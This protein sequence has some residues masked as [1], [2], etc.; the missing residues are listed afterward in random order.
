MRPAI[1]FLQ[2][3]LRNL[4]TIAAHRPSLSSIF[5]K[6][7]LILNPIL[8]QNPVAM[9]SEAEKQKAGKVGGFDFRAAPSPHAQFAGAIFDAKAEHHCNNHDR[10]ITFVEE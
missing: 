4:K 9:S 3:A 8:I 10:L 5:T 2:E 6:T 7:P 1:K